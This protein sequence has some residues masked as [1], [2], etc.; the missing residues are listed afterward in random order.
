MN[1]RLVK[2]A[3][4]HGFEVFDLSHVLD[5]NATGQVLLSD[6]LHLGPLGHKIIAEAFAVRLARFLDDKGPTVTGGE[7]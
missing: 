5:R 7:L 4:R 2:T 3:R 6:G 1:E